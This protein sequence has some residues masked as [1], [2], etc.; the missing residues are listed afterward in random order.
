MRALWS[1]ENVATPNFAGASPAGI[2]V[3]TLDGYFG[4][5]PTYL[6]WPPTPSLATFPTKSEN[7]VAKVGV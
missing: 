1:A 6:V 5:T 3:D 2:T 7:E 4:R